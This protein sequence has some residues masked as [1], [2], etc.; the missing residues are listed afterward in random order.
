MVDEWI[1]VTTKELQGEG[2]GV[3]VDEGVTMT[4]VLVEVGV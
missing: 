1:L 4:G 2:V 3:A